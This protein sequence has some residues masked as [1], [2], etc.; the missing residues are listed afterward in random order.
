MALLEELIEKL[1]EVQLEKGRDM[2]RWVLE[3]S[4]RYSTKS[5]SDPR[6]GIVDHIWWKF[7]K[8]KFL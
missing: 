1:S 7:G 8:A 3:K 4:G 5:L 2:V 6:Q